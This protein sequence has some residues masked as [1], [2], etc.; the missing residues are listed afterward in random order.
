MT[1]PYWPHPSPWIHWA[2]RPQGRFEDAALKRVGSGGGGRP[3]PWLWA[4]ASS[5]GGS[6]RR[7]TPGAARR[8]RLWQT[9][10]PGWL[11]QPSGPRPPGG[12][13]P[14]SF[15]PSAAP[16]LPSGPFK[17]GTA[18]ASLPAPAPGRVAPTHERD[19]GGPA[20]DG[21]RREARLKISRIASACWLLFLLG[22]KVLPV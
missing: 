21:G 6:G 20:R 5:R 7:P 19:R 17:N 10:E 13:S 12:N 1:Q 22:K 9:R 18:A 2:D 15:R 8:A 3:S 14:F 11:A 4:R 16:R